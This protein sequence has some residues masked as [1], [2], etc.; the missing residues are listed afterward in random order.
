MS[1]LCDVFALT[2]EEEEV[3]VGIA[4]PKFGKGA[5][6]LY[7]FADGLQVPDGCDADK[8]NAIVTVSYGFD[9]NDGGGISVFDGAVGDQCAAT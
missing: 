3:D 9:T 1:G 6:E 7:R 2:I 4:R 5:F 8:G